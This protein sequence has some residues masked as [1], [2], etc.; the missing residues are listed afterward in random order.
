MFKPT[1]GTI[2]VSL[3]S[4]KKVRFHM[5][6]SYPLSSRPRELVSDPPGIKILG[7][8]TNSVFKCGF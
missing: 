3:P 7:R 2:A 8:R 6:R 5:H 1:Y 4:E